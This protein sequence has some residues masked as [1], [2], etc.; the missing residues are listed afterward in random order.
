MRVP[1]PL[2]LLVLLLVLAAPAAVSQ[3]LPTPE[4]HFGFAMGTDRK[5]ARWDEILEYLTLLADGSA[6][7]RVDTVGPTTLGNPY[8]AVTVSSP[9]N[10]ARLDRIRA[11]SKTLAEGRVG[12]EEAEALAGDLPVTAFINHNIHSTEIASSQTSVDLVYRLATADDP[13]TREILDN[14]V[15]VLVPSANPDGQIMVVDWYRGNVGTDFEDARMPWLYHHYAGHDNNRDYFQARLVETQHWMRLMYHTAYP[16]LYLD[17]HQMGTSGPRIFVPPYPDPMNPDVHPLQWQALRLMGGAIVA[18]LQRA[19]KQG[20]ITSALYRIWG[21]EGALTGRY[22]NIVALLTESAS[23][24]IASPVTVTREQLEGSANRARDVARYGFNMQMVDPWWGGEWT[25]GDIVE[26]QTVAAFAYLTQAARYRREY[27]LGRWQMASET[28]AR[29]EREGPYAYVIPADQ[30]DLPTTTDLVR[31]LILQGVEVHQARSSFE[32]E[33]EEGLRAP[34]ASV[35]EDDEEEADDDDL[36]R[37]PAGSWVVL[38]SQPGRA[39]VLDLLQPVAREVLREYPDG[40]YTRSYDGAAYTMPLQMGVEAVRVDEPF[41]ADL[42][43]VDDAAPAPTTLPAP[44]AHYALDASVNASYQAAN[45]LLAQGIPVLRADGWFLVP[46]SDPRARDAL[47]ALRHELGLTVA[48]DP[49]DADGAGVLRASRVGLYQGWAASMDEGWT[50]L[51]L[52]QY[53]FDLTVLSNDDVRAG[54]LGE[55][56]DVV[57]LPSE[58]PLRRLLDGAAEDDAPPEYVGGIG[59]E[60][61]DALKAFVRGGGTLVTLDQGDQVVLE[62]F[63][64]PVRDALQ[65]VSSLDFFAPSSLFRLE[66]DDGHPL[67]DG[68]PGEVAAKWANGRAYEPTGFG[69]EA[70]EIRAVAGWAEDADRLLMSGLLVGAEHLAGKAAI[71]DVGYGAGHIYMYGFRV[72]HRAQTAATFRLLFNALMRT[73]PR[74]AT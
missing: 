13:A 67:S 55:R 59:M 44:R 46:A 30:A 17:Q 50:R 28:M 19:G 12:R 45:R 38:A 25:L 1:R 7:M 27:V 23:A 33:P 9:A 56:F 40:P 53:G 21:Q 48:A 29:G 10:L 42:V 43:P 14:V 2:A 70:S 34:G 52:E 24:D 49:A 22:H 65:G 5:L 39:A 15:M 35:L 68:T 72:Q 36:R 63:D 16:Q 3:T 69:G 73:G 37:F 74:T 64:V 26:Y 61:V 31:T 57:I 4:E 71:L 18:D 66:V 60:G 11:S 54:D 47:E 58:I 8:V 6:R 20:V 41:E 32:A 51:L 62:H